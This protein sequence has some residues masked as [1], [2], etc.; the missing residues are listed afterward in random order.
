M[1]A[2]E[3]GS[4]PEK[5]SERAM[6]MVTMVVTVLVGAR[7]IWDDEG[8]EDDGRDDDDRDCQQRASKE[9]CPSR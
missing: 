4:H 8:A 9:V 5:E 2:P 3:L 1:F 7:F 6:M